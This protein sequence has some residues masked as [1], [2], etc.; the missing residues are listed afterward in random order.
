MALNPPPCLR[1]PEKKYKTTAFELQVA[2]LL[3]S[4]GCCLAEQDLFA[5]T[6]MS[7]FFSY[8]TTGHLK[9]KKS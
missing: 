7:G 4:P 8:Y 1:K 3:K 5:F 6:K 2:F 9:K